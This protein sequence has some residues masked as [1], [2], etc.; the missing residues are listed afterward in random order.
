MNLKQRLNELSLL[1]GRE[2]SDINIINENE[3]MNIEN[4][5]GIANVTQPFSRCCSLDLLGETLF[6]FHNRNNEFLSESKVDPFQI[7]DDC[8]GKS[9]I[10]EDHRG[11]PS[12]CIVI[13]CSEDTR[14]MLFKYAHAG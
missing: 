14:K 6:E 4:E 7:Y 12:K 8:I 1:I 3:R 2:D 10:R 13:K 11:V 5:E 9:L